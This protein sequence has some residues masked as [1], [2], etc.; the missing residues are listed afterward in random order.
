MQY[1]ETVEERVAYE[2]AR[3]ERYGLPLTLVLFRCGGSD[4][5]SETLL[6]EVGRRVR[7]A[8]IVKPMGDRLIVTLL[9]HTGLDG[10]AGFAK[11]MIRDLEEAGLT[12]PRAGLAGLGA[13]HQQAA[14]LMSEADGALQSTSIE[15]PVRIHGEESVH[16][17]KL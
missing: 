1:Q 12:D 10:G 17:A 6:D 2:M 7:C 11:R 13:H 4:A 3:A 15:E 5:V 14:D 9:P 16:R 8:D